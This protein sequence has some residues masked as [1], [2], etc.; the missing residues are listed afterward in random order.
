MTVRYTAWR[1]QSDFPD[2][3]IPAIGAMSLGVRTRI[4]LRERAYRDSTRCS[5]RPEVIHAS[6]CSKDIS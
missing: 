4:H 1:T 6:A 2:L 5:I 3:I